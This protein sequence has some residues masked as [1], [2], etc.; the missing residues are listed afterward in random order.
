MV[1]TYKTVWNFRLPVM[2]MYLQSK[3]HKN[4]KIDY[5]Q[6]QNTLYIITFLDFVKNCNETARNI[7]HTWKKKC[8]Y[9]FMNER[10]VRPNERIK[11]TFMV[12]LIYSIW[13]ILIKCFRLRSR[14]KKMDYW[15]TMSLAI[16]R[17]SYMKPHYKESRKVIIY[18]VFQS[19]QYMNLIVWNVWKKYGRRILD[20]FRNE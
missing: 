9:F 6:L 14:Q 19:G 17:V 16:G 20:T 3:I 13:A 7:S 10:N 5:F 4:T 8:V 15:K 1:K 11:I 12:R 18:G 2:N